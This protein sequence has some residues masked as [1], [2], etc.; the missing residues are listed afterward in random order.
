MGNSA[1]V[2]R[3]PF[4]S[5]GLGQEAIPC[6]VHE[7]GGPRGVGKRMNHHSHVNIVKIALFNQF[8][9]PAQKGDF[10]FFLKVQPILDLHVLLCGDPQE[11]HRPGQIPATP[12]PARP[13]AVPSME[14]TWM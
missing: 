5:D 3:F 9:F 4:V 1:R 10:P 8:L 6:P 13:M 2:G 14:A 11:F 12:A 7:E